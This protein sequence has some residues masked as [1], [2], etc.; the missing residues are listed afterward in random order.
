[1]DHVREGVDAVSEMIRRHPVTEHYGWEVSFPRTVK[2]N[3]N[4]SDH[5]EELYRY[6]GEGKVS[7]TK[8]GLC[9]TFCMMM[10]MD[11]V[12]TGSA[13][14]RTFETL[15]QRIYTDGDRKSKIRAFAFGMSVM[16]LFLVNWSQPPI[17]NPTF[18][19]F[20]PSSAAVRTSPP[21]KDAGIASGISLDGPS[22]KRLKFE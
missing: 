21:G 7:R 2:L 6:F 10:I 20:F 11:E 15:Y 19:L 5:E 12:C 18:C 3:F 9:F 13:A 4:A 22:K 17:E 1:V 8:G 16:T 14:P